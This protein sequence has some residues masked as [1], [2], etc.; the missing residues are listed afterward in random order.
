VRI[1][2]RGSKRQLDE[3]TLFLTPAEAK[4]L[5]DTAQQLAAQPETD[6]SHVLDSSLHRQITVAVYTP[7][8]IAGYDQESRDIIGA[9]D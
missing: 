1:W 7:D 2:D 3:V 5:A 4:E 6:H 8:N 9:G